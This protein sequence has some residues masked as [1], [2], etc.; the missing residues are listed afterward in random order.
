[1]GFPEDSSHFQHWIFTEQQLDIQRRS[2]LEAAVQKLTVQLEEKGVSPPADLFLDKNECEFLISYFVSQLLIV[3]SVKGLDYKVTN[4]AAAFLT[5]FYLKRSLFE[6]DPRRILLTCILLSIKSEDLAMSTT[7]HRFCESL[8]SPKRVRLAEVIDNELVVLDAISFHLL[9]L[10]PRTP[11]HFLTTEYFQRYKPTKPSETASAEEKQAVHEAQTAFGKLLEEI[12]RD[13]EQLALQAFGNAEIPFLYTPS[14][15]GIAT[16]LHVSE[17]KL[18]DAE[19][20]VGGLFNAS[21]DK[22]RLFD[23]LRPKLLDLRTRLALMV[24]ERQQEG[25]EERSQRAAKGIKKLEKLAKLLKGGRV[26]TETPSS[27]KETETSLPEQH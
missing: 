26:P 27:P 22:A 10:Q 13:A 21:D 8:I 5:R 25:D 16:F 2:V 18:Q 19:K 9:V 15:I 23:S 11:I 20:F 24:E 4:T 6:F 7:L 1:M 3:C 12:K 14:Q 17:G